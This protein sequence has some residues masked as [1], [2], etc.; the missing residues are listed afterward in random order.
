MFQKVQPFRKPLVQLTCAIFYLE[1][2]MLRAML[3]THFSKDTVLLSEID[4]N[5][6]KNHEFYSLFGGTLY[7]N[8]ESHMNFI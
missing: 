4:L 1:N 8:G 5:T 3:L 6:A 7:E 2:K